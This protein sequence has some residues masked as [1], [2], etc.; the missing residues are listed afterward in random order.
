MTFFRRHIGWAV[1]VSE[2]SHVF[3]CVLPTVITVL[4]AL[5]NI[6]LVSVAPHFVSEIH[7][8]IHMHEAS[9]IIFSAAMVLLG[10][11]VH[12]SSIKVDCH[13]TGCVHPPCDPVKTKNARVLVIATILFALNLVIYFGVHRN[14]FG[15]EIFSTNAALYM[16]DT[17]AH[18][19]EQD[20]K[21][22]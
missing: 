15:F 12:L 18:N 14:V 11:G 6:G 10:W 9:I 7:D 8:T 21:I 13:N 17:H 4:G 16:N 1:V 19:H 3:C 22:E 20:G 2:L 5:A